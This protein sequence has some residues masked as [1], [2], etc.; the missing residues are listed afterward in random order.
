MK[1]RLLPSIALFAIIT[2]SVVVAQHSISGK[3]TTTTGES[4]PGASVVIKETYMG[5]ATN[6]SGYFQFSKLPNQSF[7]LEV[8]FIGYTTQQKTVVINNTDVTVDFQMQP[9][10]RVMDEFT[11]IAVKASEKTPTTYTELDKT[12]IEKS[13]FGQDLTY[14]LDQTPSTVV[15]SDAGAGVGYTGIRIRGVDPTR[16]NVTINGIPINDAESHGVW[17]VNMPDLVSSTGTIQVQRGVGTSTNGAAAFGAS[18]NIDAH[19]KNDSAYAEIGNTFGSFQTIRHTVKLGTGVIN[20]KFSLDGRLSK[21][22]SNGYI[23]R[24]SSDL[25]SYYLSGAYYL[26]KSTIRATIFS[27]QEKTYQA[28]YGTPE[29]RIT[30]DSAAMEA[31]VERN[32]LSVEE[33]DN[34]FSSGRTYN[35]YTYKNETD[36]YQQDHYQLHYNTRIKNISLNVSGHYTRGRGYYE[37]YRKNDRFSTY[38]FTPIV[39]AGN[40]V[41]FNEAFLISGNDT[42][43]NLN[44]GQDTTVVLGGSTINRTDLIRRRWL[45]NHFYGMVY[46]LNYKKGNLEVT[47]GGGANIYDGDHFGEV[48][49]ARYAAESEIGQRYYDNNGTKKEA[50]TY[51]K[52]TYTKDK[53]TVFGDVQYRYISYN[54]LGFDDVSNNYQEITQQVS[55]HFFNPKVGALYAINDAQ[56][57]YGSFSVG[58]REPVRNDLRESS[59]E[60]RPSHETLYNVEAGH[61]WRSRKLRVNTNVYAMEYKNQLILTGQINDVGA[62]NRTNVPVSYRRGVELE[63]A[64]QLTN[65]WVFGLNA[66]LSRNK[67]AEFNEY[68]DNYDT[69]DQEVI[70]HQNTD[71]AFS[72]NAI[73]GGILSYQPSKAWELSVLPKYVSRQYLDNTQ[74]INRSMAGYFVSHLRINY[75]LN[76]FIGKEVR[77]GLL[78]NNVLNKMYENNGY[79]FSYIYGGETI[80]ENFYYPQAGRNFLFN[81]T[82]KF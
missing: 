7:T 9:D 77:V 35:Y 1:T 75:A 67:I 40:S 49:W 43:F 66:N 5:V 16:T 46:A 23:D 42:L 69:W 32:G 24:A 22:Q 37:Q 74:D 68:I 81:I 45:D 82:L 20:N 72:P 44:P 41:T 53:W 56:R 12:T 58:N 33:R 52:A 28:W 27:G 3:V 34:L 29:S 6:S 50:H 71:M 11:T 18:I 64:Y 65:K 54:F 76:N 59:P 19:G 13:N 10:T 2:P 4:L 17:W 60:S 25:K 14:V 38:G 62:Y 70:V 63:A 55:Y 57:V 26:P 31:Y 51:A 80:T 8:K 61:Q 47:W 15:T 73:V 48:I 79:T 78:I 36:N 21:I 39:N 30:G